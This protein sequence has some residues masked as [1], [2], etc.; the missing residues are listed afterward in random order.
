MPRTS[1]C[2]GLSVRLNVSHRCADDVCVDDVDVAGDTVL[3]ITADVP[4]VGL[5]ELDEEELDESAACAT[6]MEASVMIILGAPDA[7]SIRFSVNMPN[8]ATSPAVVCANR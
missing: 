5:A 3:S 4:V 6:R 8:A 7:G 2:T 1:S